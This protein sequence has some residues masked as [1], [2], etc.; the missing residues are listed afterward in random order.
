MSEIKKDEIRKFIQEK[1]SVLTTM[2]GLLI[3]GKNTATYKFALIQSILK[4]NSKSEIYYHELRDDF[5]RLFLTYYQDNKYQFNIGETKFTKAIDDYLKSSMTGSDWDNLLRVAEKNIYNH[6]FDAFQNVGGG[7]LTEKHLFFD[8]DKENKKIIVRDNLNMILENEELRNTVNLEAEFRRKVVSEA[9]SSGLNVNQLIF[10]KESGDIV[11]VSLHRRTSLKGVVDVLL[12]Y[13]KGRCF[14]CNKKMNRFEHKDH[15]DFP[16][17]EH[18]FP[19]SLI[20]NDPE[21]DLNP[22][23]MWNVVVSCMNC[24]RG[25]D[26]KFTA[27]VSKSFYEKLKNRNI[28]FVEEHEHSLRNSILFSLQAKNKQEVGVK[29]DR[30]NIHYSYINGWAPKQYFPDDY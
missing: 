28:L 2:R 30:V 21:V 10:N 5:V 29:M 16:E 7:T 12:P 1:S 24:N 8:H 13:Q 20:L 27:P 6:V 25:K 4:H 26:G 18:V 15:P 11:S 3:F 22:D 17:G 14:Y 19:R 9:W 23:A